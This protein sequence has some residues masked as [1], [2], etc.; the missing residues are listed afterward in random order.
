MWRDDGDVASTAGPDLETLDLGET[1]GH[2][3]QQ[4]PHPLGMRDVIDAVA[5][6]ARYAL[7]GGAVA[8][9]AI[10]GFLVGKANRPPEINRS[11][12]SATGVLWACGG[13]MSGTVYVGG[14]PPGEVELTIGHHMMVGADWPAFEVSDAPTRFAVSPA[15]EIHPNVQLPDSGGGPQISL[16]AQTADGTTVAKTTILRVPCA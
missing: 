11:P 2:E 3:P 6:A 4:R 10:F 8:V 5:Q 7:I 14:L 12:I 1:P 15:G 9:A 13:T 16:E